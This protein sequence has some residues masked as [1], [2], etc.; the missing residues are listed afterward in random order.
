MTVTWESAL[1]ECEARIDEALAALVAGALAPVS[2]F[3][4]PAGIGPLPDALAERA[5]ACSERSSALSERLTEE[6]ERVRLELRRL[7]RMPRTP[8]ETRFEA[9]A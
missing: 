6:L 5:R 1:A 9:Q 7:P 3:S 4:D 2:P 8:G